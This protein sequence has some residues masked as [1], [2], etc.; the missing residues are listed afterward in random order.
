MRITYIGHSTVL[1]EMDGVRVLTD[2]LVRSRVAH[3]SRRAPRPSPDAW[4]APDIVLISHL[5]LDHFD[6]ASLRRLGKD[7]RVVVPRGAG[8]LLRRRGFSRVDEVQ[9]GEDVQAAPVSIRAVPASHSGFRPPL[10]PRAD[11]LGFVIAGS[12]HVYFP[13]DTDLF[14]EMAES[15]GEV[16]VALM[17]VWGWGRTLGPGHL[18]PERAAEAA[19]LLRP[20]LVIPIHWGTFSPIGTRRGASSFL[21]DPPH[22]FAKRAALLAPDVAV[23]ILQPGESME[24]GE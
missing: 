3:L 15:V 19:A 6:I 20:R 22:T 23:K 10:G 17:P 21:V 24:I 11:A 1:I 2:P 14:P 16:D 4:S 5:H 18:T 7:R 8:E 13:G 12:R 9:A